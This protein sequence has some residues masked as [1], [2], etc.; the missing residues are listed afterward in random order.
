MQLVRLFL[1]VMACCLLVAAL[2][3]VCCWRVLRPRA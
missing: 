3:P 1:S 2:F